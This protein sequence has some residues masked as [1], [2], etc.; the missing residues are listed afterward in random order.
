MYQ[1]RQQQQ[2][3]QPQQQQ[4]SFNDLYNLQRQINPQANTAIDPEL[5]RLLTQFLYGPA[6]DQALNELGKRRDQYPELAIILWNSFGLMTACMHEVLSIMPALTTRT[7]TSQQSNQVCNALALFQSV[8]SHP[9][10]RTA[11]LHTQIPLFLYPLLNTHAQNP[12]EEKQYEFL[13]LTTLGIIGALVKQDSPEVINFLIATEIVPI[14]LN[15]MKNSTDLNK[16]M[17]IFIVNKVLNDKSGFEYICQ[18]IERFDAVCN[19][20]ADMINDIKLTNGQSTDRGGSRVLR[21]IIKCYFRLADYN[22]GKILLR[23][24]LPKEFTNGWEIIKEES[25]DDLVKELVKKVY[26]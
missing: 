1:Q 17:A 2:P 11:F 16:T 13:K 6:K 24:K 18:T 21:H 4:P 14:C 15:I 23:Q 22:D 10:T 25:A 12:N 3:Q 5:H 26:E 9:E 20:L 8:A 7:L 19:V